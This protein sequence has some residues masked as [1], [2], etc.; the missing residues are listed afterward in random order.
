MKKTKKRKKIEKGDFGYFKSE[1]KRRLILTAILLG[2]PLFIFATMW[3]YH[4][5]KKIRF[6][7][8]DR[9]SPDAC[10][11]VNPW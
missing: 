2:V 6:V 1:K 8:S 11:A 5:N 7:D 10:L 4:A 9:S 3:A